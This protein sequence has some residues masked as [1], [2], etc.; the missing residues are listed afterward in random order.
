MIVQREIR[1]EFKRLVKAYPVVTI[2]GPRQSGKITLARTTFPEFPYYSMEDPDI[3]EM[4]LS[5][6][7]SFLEKSPPHVIL[8]EIQ[9]A[10]QLIS[11]IQGIV[12]RPHTT[13]SSK[14]I[15]TGSYQFELMSKIS[16]SLAG[17]T[18]LLKLLPFTLN[19]VNSFRKKYTVDELLI[20]GFYP[21]IYHEQLDPVPAYKFYFET[22]IQRDLR[23]LV[24]IKDLRLFQ[25]FVRLC[26]GRVG[27]IF[28]ANSLSNEV[29]VSVP[30]IHSWVSVLEASSIIFFLEP[31]H[32]NINKRLTKSPKL[33]FHDV[34]LASYLLGVENKSQIERDPARGGLFENLIVSEL[35]KNRY[36]AGKDHNLFF[37]RDS[38]DNEVDV[39]FKT[40]NKLVPVEIKSAATYT[41]G[42]IKGLE[43][44][45]KIIPDKIDKSYL[46]YCGT[47]EQQIGNV[48]LIN[49]KN[50]R[51]IVGG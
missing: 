28:I 18:A 38:N 34:G 35:V 26:A 30:T 19:E 33:Y 50:A 3:R 16:Q 23:Q 10:P 42:F 25:K 40:G 49:F 21:R 4:A 11:Y 46:V 13:K 45:K 51:G 20:R 14:F 12:D 2:T 17:R 32:E 44:I 6:P 39:L 29:G 1:S 37:Y 48:H 36:N 41:P 9:Q 22:Y 15:L 8:D 27:R 47:A 24:A 7:R 5:D 43:Y 31:Y